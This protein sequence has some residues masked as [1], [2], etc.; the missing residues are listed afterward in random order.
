MA[1]FTTN[2]KQY[3]DKE[4]CKELQ[5]KILKEQIKWVEKEECAMCTHHKSVKDSDMGYEVYDGYCDKHIERKDGDICKHFEC[6]LGG[7]KEVKN[8][9][10]R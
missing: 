4:R 1:T 7:M 5:I 3:K 6:Y 2:F 9:G 8:S 10:K